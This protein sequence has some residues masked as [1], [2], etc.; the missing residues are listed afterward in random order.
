M[1]RTPFII[2]GTTT[3]ITS[4]VIYY[5]YHQQR[6]DRE[7]M[8]AGVIRDIEREKR[9]LEKLKEDEEKEAARG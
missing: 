1:S 5:V 4:G 8:H 7:R 3:L 6:V 2:F 9:R